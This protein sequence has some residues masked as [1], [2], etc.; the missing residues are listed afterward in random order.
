MSPADIP[1]ELVEAEQ[2][3]TGPGAPFEV[4]EEQ[5]LGETMRVFADR[6][7]SLREIFDNATTMG[8]APCLVFSDGQTERRLSFAE[9]G[10]QVAATANLLQ[11]DFGVGPGDRVA[12]LAANC[13]EWIVTFWATISLGGIAVGLNGWWKG[14]EI[15]YGLQDS[16]PKVLVADQKRLQRLGRQGLSVPVISIE[17][18]FQDRIAPYFGSELPSAD[19]NEDDPAVILYTSGTTGR[20]KGAVQTHRNIIALMMCNFFSGAR[21][22][23][24][25][26]PDDDSPENCVMVTSP[27]F[28]VSGLHNAAVTCLAS[29]T[30]SVWFSGR[31]DAGAAL[32]LIESEQVTAWGFTQTLLHR[33]LHHPEAEQTDLS[34][35]RTL[36]GGGSVIPP[37]LQDRAR[38][39][40]PNIRP[41]LGVGYGLTECGS[42][43]TLNVGKELAAHPKSV[44]RPLPLVDIEIRDDRGNGVADGEHGE[45]CI[46]S[47]LVM[48]EYWRNPQAT[49]QA[50]F[51]GRWLRSGDYGRIDD[52]RLFLASRMRDLIIRGGENIY[53]A[54]IEQRLVQHPEVAEAAVTG[55]DHPELGQEVKAWVVPETGASLDEHNLHAWVADALA[56]FKIPAHW[57]IR[58]TPLPRN[59]TGKVVK[60]ALASGETQFIGED[61]D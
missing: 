45:V 14:P 24:A 1:A 57:E 47:P 36:G 21:L 34:S 7:G 4:V 15:I 53:P 55:V 16:A 9:L 3:L 18:E 37:E 51:P 27:L 11:Q 8:D 40:M 49:E 29:G 32:R 5:V 60:P 44:G 58:V 22:A 61:E 43:A 30:R 26:P 17:D 39:L 35:I 50:F 33:L 56:D 12:I 25:Y 28:H 41:T 54:E 20:S 46:R 38:Q 6:P 48:L 19:I 2:I 13:P 31:F 59:A 52:G 10:A 42:L 23:M